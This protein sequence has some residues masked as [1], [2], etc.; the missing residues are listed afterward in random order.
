MEASR[1]IKKMSDETMDLDSNL[2]FE[3]CG[4]QTI[5][6]YLIVENEHG[7]YSLFYDSKQIDFPKSWSVFNELDLTDLVDISDDPLL[8]L[9]LNKF[10]GDVSSYRVSKTE[11]G[12]YLIK[13][14]YI[15]KAA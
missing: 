3:G 6:H 2:K 13:T 9:A 7:F 11:D 5:E 8:V 1:L 4:A 15:K 10:F 12:I 14:P